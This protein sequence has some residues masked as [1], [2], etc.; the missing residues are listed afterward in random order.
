MKSLPVTHPQSNKPPSE[1]LRLGHERGVWC[2]AVSPD[3]KLIASGSDEF[4]RL[5]DAESGKRLQDPFFDA[6]GEV[7][8]LAFSTNGSRLVAEVVHSWSWE[9]RVFEV[10][11]GEVEKSFK[12]PEDIRSPVFSP[13]GRYIAFGCKT[14]KKRLCIISS[15]SGQNVIDPPQGHTYIVQSVAYS[16]DGKRL[17]SA[18][19]DKTVRVWD[20]STG[21]LVAGPFEGHSGG[22]NSVAFS[23]D[24]TKIVSGSDDR[25]V[26]VWDA[27]TGEC[28][29]VCEGH[30]SQVSSVSFSPDGVTLASASQDKTIRIWDATAGQP[31]VSPLIWHTDTVT[32]IAFLPDGERIVSASHD[33]TVCIGYWNQR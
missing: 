20:P 1:V 28:L 3:G 16:R 4:I 14:H 17:V 10:A 8:G 32:S 25:T 19:Y 22:V 24:G 18:S 2:V 27:S 13:D 6:D 9:I 29:F 33:K 30:T 11:S 21:K 7:R 5:W 26:R 31:K 23:F 12:Q 15:S